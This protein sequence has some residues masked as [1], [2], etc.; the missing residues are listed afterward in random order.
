MRISTA[1]ILQP[2]II[3]FAWL[4]MRFTWWKNGCIQWNLNLKKQKHVVAFG[5]LLAL[6]SSDVCQLS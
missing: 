4:L 1:D 5:V 6:T 3:L 2:R